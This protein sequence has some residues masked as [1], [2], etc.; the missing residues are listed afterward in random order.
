MFY[1]SLLRSTGSVGYMMINAPKTP[2]FT[3]HYGNQVTEASLSDRR[4][5]SHDIAI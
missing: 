1:C 4:I 2:S 5:T 3:H